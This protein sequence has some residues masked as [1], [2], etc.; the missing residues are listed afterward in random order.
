MMHTATR[1]GRASTADLIELL[2]SDIYPKL[3]AEELF[4][5][6]GHNWQPST[7]KL[8][9]ACPWHESHSGTSFYVD[10]RSL[11]WRCAG[12]NV[13]GTPIQYLDRIAGGDGRPRGQRFVD[14]CR[15]LFALAGVDFPERDAG[16]EQ[17]ERAS[18]WE[19]YRATLLAIGEICQRHLWLPENAKAVEYLEF[20]RGLSHESIREFGLGFWPSNATVAAELDA[21]QAMLPM[22]LRRNRDGE[23]PA[24]NFAGHV[25]IPWADESG[26]PLT[27]YVAWPGSREGT[28][29]AHKKCFPN[30]KYQGE[31]IVPGKKSPLCLD[32]ALAAGRRDVVV[33]EG[34]FDVLVAQSRG[35]RRVVACVAA[36]FSG[37]QVE[38]LRKIGTKSV[39]IA[40][41]PDKAGVE[42][43][44]SC[45][46]Q[47]EA[48]G[49]HSYVAP[50][51]PDGQDPDD[52][53]LANSI[54]A[55][56]EH[57]DQA[58]GG[59]T[60]LA[61]QAIGDITPDS[62]EKAR[63][64]AARRACASIA[65]A[66][67]SDKL[68][69][70]DALREVARAT[71]YQVDDLA[72]GADAELSPESDLVRYSWRTSL[73]MAETDFHVEYLVERLL[74]AGQPC[75]LGGPKKCLKTSL[76]VDLGVTLAVG[77]RFLGVL[78]AARVARTAIMSGE[79]GM[80]TLKETASRVA[81]AAGHSLRSLDH[82]FWSE[83]LPKFADQRHHDALREFLDETQVEV[84]ILDPAYLCMPAADAANLMAQ[85]ELLR[86]VNQVCAEFN[87]TMVL[88]HHTRKNGKADKDKW[89]EPELED[90]AWAG[91]QE[92]ARQW[93]L[94]GRRERY[95]PGSGLHKLWV[96][97]GGSMGHSGS[98]AV[99]VDEGEYSP[100][101]Q[102]RWEVDVKSITEAWK[103]T[104][105]AAEASKAARASQQEERKQKRLEE[106]V[107]AGRIR[108]LAVLQRFP[109]G[110]T[111]NTVKTLVAINKAVFE[112]AWNELADD[113]EIEA[114]LVLKGTRKLQA[115]KVVE[116]P[117]A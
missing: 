2:E 66:G 9:G 61:R 88:A 74:V 18:I 113:G 87:V 55:W 39:T 38:T 60:W 21:A 111:K 26:R 17:R 14:S 56:R 24:T 84:L 71:G 40:L 13:G 34:V 97:T 114:T 91:F 22:F 116:C 32:R 37:D 117:I 30:L 4:S 72:T 25:L 3:S 89:A 58:V 12:C 95:E 52:F 5:W 35:D 10:T 31:T 50:E 79:S 53:I 7:G 63:Q 8:R 57:V 75:I 28:H 11:L 67:S 107:A 101:V 100:G 27:C 54:D 86:G 90:L 98:W 94:T 19:T 41:D 65:W 15:Q 105:E 78:P 112:I 70:R 102:R 83:D 103:E 45:I 23:T 59:L 51:L 68:A 64:E 43:V 20:M 93:I 108:I 62:P 36:Q 47:C 85:G 109:E 1:N 99:D 82:L 48:K 73:E 80:A 76:L 42:G 29:V 33:T 77:G 92:W 6:P 104:T 46:R 81:Q 44:K 106:A 49:I 115:W 96:V 16:P 69:V 110:E